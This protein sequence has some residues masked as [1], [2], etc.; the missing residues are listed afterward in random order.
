MLKVEDGLPSPASAAFL[1]GAVQPCTVLPPVEGLSTVVVRLSNPRA[2]GLNNTNRVE[3]EVAA[4]HL[5]RVAVAHLGPDSAGLVPAVY[6]WKAAAS[7]DPVDETG[8]GWMLMEFVQG[9]PLDAHFRTL[10]VA[11]K[12]GVVGQI[13][14]IF[15][16]IQ[17]A[18]LPS[19]VGSYG[20]LKFDDRGAIVSG[21]PTL[22]KGGPWEKYE[23]FWKAKFQCELEQAEENEV[24]NGWYE[25]GIRERINSFINTKL[26]GLLRR[27]GIT[28]PRLALIHGDL[29]ESS[30]GD[31]PFCK[32]DPA[33]QIPS[34]EQHA[35]R[36]E[37]E[38]HHQ[39]SRL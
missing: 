12:K 33:K 32:D 16:A 30:F 29:S 9:V 21:Q 10:S 19:G 6:A 4:L 35:R 26:D 7:P 37:D 27:A 23:D 5:A 14:A 22:A 34:H 11:E 3:N 31:S 36:S 17:S 38:P 1:R 18:E 2:H 28:T 25:N 20:G 8:F 39:L 15:S 24:M 13:A